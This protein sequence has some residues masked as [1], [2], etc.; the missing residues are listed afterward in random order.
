M[1]AAFRAVDVNTNNPAVNNHV[2]DKPAGTV[3]GDVLYALLTH[4]GTPGVLTPPSG[5]TQIGNGDLSG[6]DVQTNRLYKKDAVA[7][8]GD[9]ANWTWNTT[10]GR[11]SIVIVVAVSG[12]DVAAADNVVVT[13]NTSSNGSPISISGTGVTLGA[14]DGLL[15]FIALDQDAS[16]DVWAYSAWS[17][18]QAEIAE[19]ANGLWCNAGAAMA[20]NQSAGATGSVTATATRTS[21]GGGAGW[22]IFAV[23]VPA[24]TGGSSPVLS[25]PTPSGTLGTSTTASIG[26]STDTTSG[27]G[28]CVVDS[29]ANLAGVTASQIKAGQKASGAAALAAGNVAV[30]ASPFS[31]GVTGLSPSTLYSY[32]IVQN[33]TT[34]SN[35]VTG[36]FTTGSGT[37]VPQPMQYRR[38]TLYL[39]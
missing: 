19:S 17:Q 28:Y 20:D 8:G 2:G 35:I 9:P 18:S 27:T 13:L 14:G 36:T 25:A 23:G 30:S 33:S 12:A 24:A 37:V 26:A 38:K 39:I 11:A 16:A 7:A 6:P 3:D 31:I 5:W 15:T 22:A 10:V 32:A 29:A 4:D 34:D 1:G 21:G